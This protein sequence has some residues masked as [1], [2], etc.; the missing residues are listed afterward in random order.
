[1]VKAPATNTLELREVRG[2]N[3]EGE[4]VHGIT[5]NLTPGCVHLLRG[6][7]GGGKAALLRLLGLLERP[8]VGEIIVRGMPTSVLSDEARAELRTQRFGFVFAAPFLLSSFT[9]IENVAMPLFKISQVTPEEARCRTEE[10]LGFVG[11]AEAAEW[12]VGELPPLAQY[13][14]AV[15]RGMIN[16]PS[17][18]LVENLDGTLVGDDLTAFSELLHRVTETYGTTVVATASPAISL[19]GRLRVWDVADGAITGD[20]DFSPENLS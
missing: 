17:F 16:E 13:R 20:A 19:R 8:E 12:P 4:A 15:A 18:L 9:V 7:D 3:S 6:P 2:G 10:M 14:V 11:L 1:V 5:A